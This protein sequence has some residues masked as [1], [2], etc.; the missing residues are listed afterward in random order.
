MTSC[1]S[2]AEAVAGAAWIQESLPERL[3]LKR[4][5][6]AQVE[7]HAPPDAILA[8]S[9]ADFAPRELQ[10]ET[11]RPGRILVAHPVDP[12][13]LI[14]LVE[15][16]ASPATDPALIARAEATLRSIGM[17]P[18]HRGAEGGPVARRLRA[19]L[20]REGRRLVEDGHATEAEVDAAVRL[21]PG[22][23]WAQAG[24]FEAGRLGDGEGEAPD[25]RPARD[26]HL[27][28]LL[29]ALKDRAQGAGIPLK[30]HET[31]LSPPAP[32]PDRPVPPVALERQVPVTWADYNGHMNEAQYLTAFS[33][34][35]DRLLAWAG[36]DAAC[37]AEGHSVFTVETH[38]RHL[39]EVR[40]GDRISV[41]IRV[42]EGGGRKLHIW[43]E[44]RVGDRLCATGEQ[45]LLHVD[46][47]T[48]RS[49]PPRADVALWL[50]RAARAHAGLPPPEGLGR[51]VG[52][53]AR[54]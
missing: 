49:A 2:I 24:V 50:T 14:P 3:D 47:A 37:I 26:G 21:G 19:A 36:M 32:D 29:R 52:Q 46:L 51:H 13:Y 33:N 31:T 40:I 10:A 25:P 45:L 23:V 8:S 38:I 7:A 1:S 17:T 35:C 42:L 11:T 27:V 15:V 34:A 43:Q 54:A 53:K 20:L 22:P 39:D 16:V 28:A 30:D 18:L 41:S 44:L 4:A 48:R 6:V 12:V 5:L 9:T